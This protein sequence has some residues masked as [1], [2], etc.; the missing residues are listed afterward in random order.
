MAWACM[1]LDG[2]TSLPVFGQVSLNGVRNKGDIMIHYVRHFR[3]SVGPDSILINCNAS[4]DRA[5]IVNEF[6][7]S[8]DFFLMYWSVKFPDVTI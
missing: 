5:H 4:R 7:E 2:H 8:G 1:L 3:D 6:Q